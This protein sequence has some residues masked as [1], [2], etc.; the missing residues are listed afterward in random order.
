[1]KAL[2]RNKRGF[3]IA[4]TNMIEQHRNPNREVRNKGQYSLI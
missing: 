3:F 1:M 4:Y 2:F